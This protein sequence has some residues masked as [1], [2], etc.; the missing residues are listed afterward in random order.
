MLRIHTLVTLFFGPILLTLKLFLNSAE[1]APFSPVKHAKL[2]SY[3][4]VLD[5]GHGGE[6][7]GSVATLGKNAKG[8]P[9]DVY[10]KTLVLQIAKRVNRYLR[11]PKFTKAAGRRVKVVLTREKDM[12]LSLDSRALLVRRLKADLFLSLHLNSETSGTARGFETYFLNN[13]T[14]E[15]D[16]HVEKLNRRH[17]A[18]TRGLSGDLSLLLSAVASDAMVGESRKAAESIQT[19]IS[20]QTKRDR[21]GLEN[22]G[23]RQSLLQVLLD[24]RV[25]AVLVEGA[26]LSNPADLKLARDGR[27][28]DSLARGIAT[29]VVRYLSGRHF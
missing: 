9:I 8:K 16:E 21:L 15:T 19:A 17:R 28:Q 12:A 24:A 11:D 25:P 6:D 22:R 27:A 5:P 1:A 29:G 26:F 20:Q 23:I 3:I 14:T 4:I 10:E 2:S 18:E 13:T 7:A